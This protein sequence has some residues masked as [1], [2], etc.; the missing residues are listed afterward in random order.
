MNDLGELLIEETRRR[1]RG[2]VAQMRTCLG[3]LSEE[4]IWARP[5]ESSNA[6]GNLVIHMCGSTRHFLGRGVGGADYR[7]DRPGEFAARGPMP[8]AEL[9]RMLDEAAAEIEQVLDGVTPDRLLEVNERTGKPF[10]IAQ[11]LMRVS[12]HW[13]TH[14]GQMMFDVK[15]RKPGAFDELWIK[16][17]PNL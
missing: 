8:R 12:H 10:S 2:F 7:R 15:A 6:M 17:L 5:A 11:L 13:A 1:L 3:V 4:E 9:L 14:A 16:T